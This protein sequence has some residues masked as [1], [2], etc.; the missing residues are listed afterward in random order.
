V[1]GDLP[2][3]PIRQGFGRSRVRRRGLELKEE[4]EEGR[5][6]GDHFVV[7]SLSR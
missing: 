3:A 1:D 5:Q 6:G 7:L 2:E 4:G